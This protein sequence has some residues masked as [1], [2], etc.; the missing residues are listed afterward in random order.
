M[1][2]WPCYHDPLR[3]SPVSLQFVLPPSS[4]PPISSKLFPRSVRRLSP[5][6]R[7]PCPLLH[8]LALATCPGLGSMPIRGYLGLGYM[9][10]LS[11]A[12][13]WVAL[14]LATTC[15]HISSDFLK[16]RV[17]WKTE[18][19]FPKDAA[20]GILGACPRARRAA[21]PRIVLHSSKIDSCLFRFLCP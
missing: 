18:V 10:S 5:Q 19:I 17:F 2:E 11:S 13:I 14:A 16:M 1:A 8:A 15:P 4:T 12:P 7:V 20:I 9:P 3:F 6:C 21:S